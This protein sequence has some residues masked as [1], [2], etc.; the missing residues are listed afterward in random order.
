M[1]G[2][3]IDPE[4]RDRIAANEAAFREVNEG[5]ARGQYPGEEDVPGAFRCECAR[6]GCNMM[7]ELSARD[8]E[9][10]RA[11]GRRFVLTPGHELPDV[12]VVVERTGAYV[13]VEKTGRA[14]RL[15]EESDPRD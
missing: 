10:V 15:A 1:T 12:D 6:L 13:V 14:G 7:V 3:P 8:Y 2:S 11:N 5:I 4:L 9:R